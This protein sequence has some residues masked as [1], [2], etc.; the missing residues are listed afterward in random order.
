MGEGGRTVCP[1][2]LDAELFLDKYLQWEVGGLHHLIILQRMF[3]QHVHAEVGQ[4]EVERLIC[5]GH[6]HGLPRLDPGADV[7][8]IHLV[9]YQTSWKEIQ[10]FYQKVCLPKRLPGPP[11]CGPKW[12]EESIKDILSSLRS[13]LQR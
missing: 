1:G 11:P 8:A 5:Q 10:H 7:P 12:M 2:G 9:G 13:C 6:Q 3:M 4:K